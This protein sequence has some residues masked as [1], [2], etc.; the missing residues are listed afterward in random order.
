MLIMG[1][2]K[3]N[4]LQMGLTIKTKLIL[5]SKQYFNAS[6]LNNG[7]TSKEWLMFNIQISTF[8]KTYFLEWHTV[9]NCKKLW[10]PASVKSDEEKKMCKYTNQAGVEGELTPPFGPVYTDAGVNTDPPR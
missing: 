8:N 2:Q 9:W 3:N 5:Q 4:S 10:I 6:F 1:M 7:Y